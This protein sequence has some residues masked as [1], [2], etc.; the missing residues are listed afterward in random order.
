MTTWNRGLFLGSWYFFS[1]LMFLVS[2]VFSHFTSDETV[3]FLWC[4]ERFITLKQNMFRVRFNQSL[5]V[6]ESWPFF[7][8]VCKHQWSKASDETTTMRWCGRKL[9]GSNQG[10][11]LH[12]GSVVAVWWED[13]PGESCTSPILRQ[14]G[15]E[16]VLNKLIGEKWS[17]SPDIVIRN[18]D[19]VCPTSV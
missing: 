11:Q 18:P 3:V 15:T 19:A 9:G 17:D 13:L 2:R 8:F 6:C 12:S 14:Q 16:Q 7:G 1:L 10:I 5:L 4:P